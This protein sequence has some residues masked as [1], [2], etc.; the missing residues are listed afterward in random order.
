MTAP[1]TTGPAH[2]PRP[3]TEPSPTRRADERPRRVRPANEYWDV[4]SAAWVRSDVS[5]G[6]SRGA[7]AGG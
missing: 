2:I 1:G 5:A 7:G 4:F 6:V 3:R